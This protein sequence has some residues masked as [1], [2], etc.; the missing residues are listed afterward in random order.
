M[1]PMWTPVLVPFAGMAAEA[2]A[3]EALALAGKVA[4]NGAKTVGSAALRGA[5]DVVPKI[6]QALDVSFPGT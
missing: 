3:G 4:W 6:G 5:Y 1:M 2:G